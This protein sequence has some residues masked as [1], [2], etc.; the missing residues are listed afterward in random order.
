M[1]GERYLHFLTNEIENLLEALDNFLWE[2]LKD[3]SYDR[4]HSLLELR[5]KIEQQFFILNNQLSFISN[6]IYKLGEIFQNCFNNRCS[7]VDN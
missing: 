3:K 7:Y 5:Q 6:A 4:I 1:K 2:Y